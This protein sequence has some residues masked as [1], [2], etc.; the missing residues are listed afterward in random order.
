MRMPALNQRLV[1]GH[2]RHEM[3]VP[4]RICSG[5]PLR[6]MIYHRMARRYMQHAHET[7]LLV[8]ITVAS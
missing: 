1:A 2:V 3:P 6:S 8:F 5:N 4:P 7:T